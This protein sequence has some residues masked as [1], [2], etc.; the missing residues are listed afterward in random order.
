MASPPTGAN[1]ILT[2]SGTGADDVAEVTV[3]SGVVTAV[4][5]DGA[6]RAGELYGCLGGAKFDSSAGP[7]PIGSPIGLRSPREHGAK[8]GTT[9]SWSG[10]RRRRTRGG[11]R[12]RHAGRRQWPRS[13]LGR[14]GE[15][16]DRRRQRPRYGLRRIWRCTEI[17][18]EQGDDRLYGEDGNDRVFGD[19]GR[20][21]V[22]GGRGHDL[23]YGG[24]DDDQIWGLEGNDVL[25]GQAGADWLNGGLDGDWLTAATATTR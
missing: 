3:Q 23:L 25:A 21:L 14:R 11:P 8:P 4:V 9:S 20:D 19:A 22:D 12:R 15:R 24:A 7:A 2:I 16:R 13:R 5:D 10:G 18:G 1:G 17:F 6:G